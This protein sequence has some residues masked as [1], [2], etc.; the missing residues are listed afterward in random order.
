MTQRREWWLSGFFDGAMAQVLFDPKRVK[1]ARAEVKAMLRLARLKRGARVLDA[2]CGTGRHS[3]EFARRGYA[4]TGVDATAAY[5]AAAARQAKREKLKGIVFKKGD[6]RRLQRYRG[7]FDLTVNLFTSFGYYRTEKD[8]FEVLKQ[9]SA[10]L[11]P[12]GRL[13][14]DLN[15]RESVESAF[16]P[17]DWQAVEGGY[18]MEKREWKDHGRRLSNEWILALGKGRPK[19]LRWEIQLYTLPELKALFRRAGLKKIRT[20]RDFAGNAWRLGDRLVITGTK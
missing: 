6:L 11:R 12:G 1:A 19:R 10:S 5:V 2:A 20:F 7:A 3:L 9:L 18:L 15:P 16:K 4:V 17:K 14:M 8:N 13:I